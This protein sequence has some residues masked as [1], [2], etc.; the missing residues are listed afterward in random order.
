MELRNIEDCLEALAGFT[1]PYKIEIESVDQTI[2]YSIAK[3]VFRGKALTDRQ[4]DVCQKKL[5][6]YQQQFIDQGVHDLPALVKVLRQP[7]REIDRSKYVVIEDDKIKIRFPFN[8][9]T[10]IDIE[11]IAFKHRKE[12]SH[13][14]G[15]HEHFFKINESTIYSVVEKFKNKEFEIDAELVDSY[16]KINEIKNNPSLY[17]PGIYNLQFKNVS[18]ELIES[19]TE[20]VGELT[21]DNLALFRDR[22]ILYGLDYFDPNVLDSIKQ[23]TPLSQNIIKRKNPNVFVSKN[24]W[25]LDNLFY[26]IKELNRFPILVVLGNDAYDELVTCN[27]IT[28]NFVDRNKIS[29]MFRLDNKDNKNF[30]DYIKKNGLNNSV[31]KDTEIV[32]ISSNKKYP[33]PLM[34]SDW[35]FKSCLYLQSQYNSHKID[36]ITNESDLE[37]HYDTV[38]SQYGTFRHSRSRRHLM[39]EEM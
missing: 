5:L 18:D 37:I 6:Y 17:V 26:S 9:K 30:N 33:K 39:I 2:L 27:N 19:I 38:P 8:K 23:F 21:Q 31:A 14:K 4:L 28:R 35:R 1:L 3:Q 16:N 22:S 34:S 29:V 24:K 15:T 32:Y 20:H 7:L 11:E 10:I 13:T 12:Y 36:S 25:T